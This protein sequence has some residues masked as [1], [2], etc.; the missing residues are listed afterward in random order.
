ML[1]RNTLLFHPFL[2][3][4]LHKCFCKRHIPNAAPE[5]VLSSV[6]VCTPELAK[7]NW[8]GGYALAWQH[9][10]LAFLVASNGLVEG[11]I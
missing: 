11:F 5:S 7:L 2:D 1:R 3:L 8:H 10:S 6:V 4:I 9:T